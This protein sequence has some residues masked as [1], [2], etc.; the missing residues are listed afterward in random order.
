MMLIENSFQ[1]AAAPDRVFDFLRDATNVVTCLP[2]AELVEDLGNDSYRGRVK[3]KVGPVTAAYSGIATITRQD[4]AERSAIL[5]A[6]GRDSRG[7]GSAKATTTMR[8]SPTTD[9]SSVELSTDL[10]VS[11]KLAQFGRAVM[12]D[13]SNKM[14]GELAGRVRERIEAT[15]TAD[16]QAEPAASA[17]P[18]ALK[19]SGL[20]WTVLAGVF[21][22]LFARLRRGPAK[23][24]S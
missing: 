12:T 22:R 18:A 1:V 9:G 20:V 3:V 11:G 13:V 6:E 2:G 24:P 15:T 21:R 17:E 14:V 10:S 8:V 7:N 16:S 19:A 4:M 23:D 5:V